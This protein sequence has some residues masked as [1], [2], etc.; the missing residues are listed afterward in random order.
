MF[1]FC[2]FCQQARNN[3]LLVSRSCNMGGIIQDRSFYFFNWIGLMVDG[4]KEVYIQLTPGP[5]KSGPHATARLARI[6]R[7]DPEQ[8]GQAIGKLAAGGSWQFG[9]PV[10]EDQASRAKALLEKMGFQVSLLDL[11]S[12]SVTEPEFL[13]VSVPSEVPPE[14]PLPSPRVV[15]MELAS[16]ASQVPDRGKRILIFDRSQWTEVFILICL[17]V[18]GAVFLSFLSGGSDSFLRSITE[19]VEREIRVILESK[20]M[21][22]HEKSAPRKQAPP[23]ASGEDVNAKDANGNTPIHSA[24]AYGRVDLIKELIGKGAKVDSRNH[25]QDTPLHWAAI[26]NHPSVAKVLIENGADVNAGNKDGARPL[27]LA[28]FYGHQEVAELLLFKGADIHAVAKNGWTPLQTAIN[29]RNKDLEQF[30]R[31]RGAAR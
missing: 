23:P 18:M 27:H 6:F 7:L 28:V 26:K 25:Y 2:P 9:R 31:N 15:N 17:A 19:R 12:S 14:G 21:V 1:I 5:G 3:V 11:P 30:L 29:K 13:E 16:S 8:A 4:Q 10:P 22:V 24:A 20:G